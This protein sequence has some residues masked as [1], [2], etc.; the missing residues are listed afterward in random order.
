MYVTP[1][2]IVAAG[3]GSSGVDLDF[4]LMRVDAATGVPDP[5]FG[6]GDGAVFTNIGLDQ[7]GA[8]DTTQ[9]GNTVYLGGW[10]DIGPTF[11]EA[12]FARDDLT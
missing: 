9:V 2:G 6:G 1:D 4:L 11:A 10:S 12:A 3:Q 5:T 8:T 7:D